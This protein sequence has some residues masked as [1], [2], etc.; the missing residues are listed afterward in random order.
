M[1]TLTYWHAEHRNDSQ[2]YAIRTRTKREAVALKAIYP[3]AYGEIHKVSVD[4]FSPLDLLVQ[5]TE[6]GA[7]GWESIAVTPGFVPQETEAL[8]DEV[9]ALC[10]N[11]LR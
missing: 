5:A 7:L 11:R 4:Y 3:E 6:E 9:N 8:L 2:A 1:R 10:G